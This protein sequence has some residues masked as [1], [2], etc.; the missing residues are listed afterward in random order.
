MRA[1]CMDKKHS[2]KDK[3]CPYLDYKPDKAISS[4]YDAIQPVDYS[5]GAYAYIVPRTSVE[6]LLKAYAF[7]LHALADRE[8]WNAKHGL[9]MRTVSPMWYAPESTSSIFEFSST[10]DQSVQKDAPVGNDY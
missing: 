8:W 3:I 7:P 1:F 2:V 9:R 10:A 4:R 6:K 5:G